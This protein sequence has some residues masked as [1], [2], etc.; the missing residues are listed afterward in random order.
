MKPFTGF[1]Y[2]FLP[3]AVPLL[4]FPYGLSILI[5]GTEP[6]WVTRF[7]NWYFDRPRHN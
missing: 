5:L 4:V 6:A 7:L 3:I 1:D 2:L